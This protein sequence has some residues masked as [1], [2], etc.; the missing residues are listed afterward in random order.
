MLWII[1]KKNR[2]IG[3][4]FMRSDITV[5][6]YFEKVLRAIVALKDDFMPPPDVALLD[7]IKNDTR[8]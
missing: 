3:H 7:K 4:N 5:S 1:T 6:K 8:T 2:V